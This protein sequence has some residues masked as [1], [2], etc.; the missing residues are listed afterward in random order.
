M[1]HSGKGKSIETV[2][3]NQWLSRGLGTKGEDQLRKVM[4]VDKAL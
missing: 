4:G 1:W 2:K 3:K